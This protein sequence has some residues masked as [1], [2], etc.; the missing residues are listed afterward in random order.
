VETAPVVVPPP[1][2]PKRSKTPAYITGGLA[3]ASAGIGTFFGLQALKAQSD[4]KANPTL[5]GANSG[6]NKALIADMAFGVAVTLGVTS[7]V[8]LTAKNEAPAAAPTEAPKP[9]ASNR[10]GITVHPVPVLYPSGGGAG[11]VVRF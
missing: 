8:L 7:V 5:T 6:E 11:A 10:G 2:P 9:Q 1:P 4:F 3:I